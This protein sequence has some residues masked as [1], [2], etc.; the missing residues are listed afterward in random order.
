[1]AAALSPLPG[2]PA[3]NR[4]L[5]KVNAEY[6]N[7]HH[8]YEEHFWSTKMKLEGASADKLSSSKNEYDSFLSSAARLSAVREQLNA[9]GLSAE[10]R[11][12]LSCM[13]KTFSTFITEDP[14]VEEYKAQ[15]NQ[16]E[17]ELAT[18]RNAM[19]L[20]YADPQGGAFHK[21]SSVQL[22]NTMRT[23]DDEAVRRAA[24]EGLRSI[25]PAV[26]QRF[27][28]IV[29]LRNRLASAAGYSNYYDMKVRQAEGFSLETLFDMLDGLEQ[30]TRPIMEA[31]R[32][33]LAEQ[34]GADALQPWNTGYSLAGDVEKRMDPYFP[35]ETAVDVWA[36]TFAALGIKYR[37]AT[38]N[39]DLCDREGK[40][41]NGFCHWP[42][43]AYFKSDG[44][45]VPSRTNFTSLATPSAVG[46]GKTALVTLLHEGGHAA[47][48]ANV[49]Q[50]SPLFSQERAPTSVAYAET[51]SMTLDSL[52]GDAAWL[53]RYAHN[54][55]G[56]VIPL[57]IIL[58]K[59]RSTQP[60]GVLMCRS[61]LSVPYFER[62]LYLLP[63]EEVT[64]ERILALADETEVKIEGGLAGRPLMS[65]PHILSDESSAY[66]HSYVLAEMAVHQN[67]AAF[68]AKYGAVVDE[69][70]VGRD[71][72][73]VYWAPGNGEAFLDLVQKLTG[74]PLSSAAWV[75]DLQTPLKQKLEEEEEAYRKAVAAGPAIAPG[76]QADLEMRIRLVHGDELIADT[77][78]DGGLAGACAKYTEWIRKTW[79]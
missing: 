22:R 31:A 15:L 32:K 36:R 72:A 65:V 41:S 11:H 62:A 1:M 24:Y 5:D 71:M 40:Y 53:A 79:P 47:H 21:A 46:S 38:M 59:I 23:S 74:A 58:E 52:A 13:E 57:D 34:K 9:E 66:Y 64:A 10:Q 51:Q 75:K 50:H 77:E 70:R 60:F 42:Q 48:F 18:E 63:E 68:M 33:T 44:T 6:E 2:N 29:K 78:T 19:A 73:E 14:R 28:G 76:Q 4:F 37:G 20:G 69:P 26:A 7:V 39:L 17:A 55:A 35:F 61:M 8:S 3:V 27:A 43:P 54:T 56:E 67:R 30:Q 16:L 49:L 25:G 45:W 12:V